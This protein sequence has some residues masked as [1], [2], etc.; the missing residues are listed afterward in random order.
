LIEAFEAKAEDAEGNVQLM[1]GAESVAEVSLHHGVAGDAGDFVG[2]SGKGAEIFAKIGVGD[3]AL[4]FE[5]G[6]RSDDGSVRVANGNGAGADGNF[7]SGF[8]VQEGDGV[9]GM[10]VLDGLRE[11]TV[12]AAKFAVGFV[13]VEERLTGAGRFADDFVARMAGDALGAV[14][15]E[16]DSPLR[17]D[18]SE[19]DGKAFEN[20]AADFEIVK[21]GHL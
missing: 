15:P 2:A 13:A 20:A 17:V 7:V 11:R 14:A 8:V 10:R 3:L 9:G 21:F 5:D 18:H 6:H 4:I 1:E 12:V 19:A 16:N